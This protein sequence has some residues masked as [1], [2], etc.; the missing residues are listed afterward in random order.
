MNYKTLPV[1]TSLL[2]F[3]LVSCKK[4]GSSAG[5]K[6]PTIYISGSLVSSPGQPGQGVYWKNGVANPIPNTTGLTAVTVSGNDLY[7]LS[8][9]TWWKNG[10]PTTIKD[11][12]LRTKTIAVSGSG[13][14]Y[15]AGETQSS[16]Y[17][18]TTAAIYWKNGTEVNLTAYTNV[19][20]PQ[21]NDVITWG[22]DVY[23]CGNGSYHAVYWKNGQLTQLPDGEEANGNTTGTPQACYF[24]NGTLVTLP[25]GSTATG[26]AVAGNDVYV[27]GNTSN[28]QAV[29]WKNAA[30]QTLGMGIA[31]GIAV[32]P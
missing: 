15:I 28:G 18:P 25:G 31:S 12:V 14:V 29:Y 1:L 4:S 24:K 21:T 22:T 27:V 6:E 32:I 17:Y 3:G 26:I 20:D 16:A 2:L 13:D 7:L 19:N 9:G 8:G 30:M 5:A 23:A 11:S 10:T